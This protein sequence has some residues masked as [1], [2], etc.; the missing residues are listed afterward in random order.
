M[1]LSKLNLFTRP[2]FFALAFDICVSSQ[3]VFLVGSGNVPWIFFPVRLNFTVA[4]LLC[5]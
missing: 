1:D 4:S 5:D 3:P 2:R